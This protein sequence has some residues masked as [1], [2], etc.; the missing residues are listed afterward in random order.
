M[1][2][3]NVSCVIDLRCGILEFGGVTEERRKMKDEGGRKGV[4]NRE[5]E[6]ESER[7]LKFRPEERERERHK[8]TQV[9]SKPLEKCKS[10]T[11]DKP[12]NSRISPRRKEKKNRAIFPCKHTRPSQ[13][14]ISFSH[15]SEKRKTERITYHNINTPHTPRPH[16]RRNKLAHLPIPQMHMC[17]KRTRQFDLF[18]V[19][20]T[21]RLMYTLSL[22]SGWYLSL[23]E[24]DGKRWQVVTGG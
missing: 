8:I 21:H 1:A 4:R 23:S 24:T 11:Q 10:R 13:G 3:K 16:R 22:L 2:A 12:L 19:Q 5:S 17:V 7:D 20:K 14:H 6:S 15:Q 18:Q 9:P